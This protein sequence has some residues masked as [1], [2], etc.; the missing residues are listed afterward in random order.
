[1]VAIP[2]SL[3]IAIGWIDL[4]GFGL[5]QMGNTTEA[6]IHYQKGLVIGEALV[7]ADPYNAKARTDLATAH[8][9]VGE[10]RLALGEPGAAL[11]NFQKFH[12]ITKDIAAANPDKGSAQRELGVSLFKM[13]EFHMSL[14]QD[15]SR[16]RTERIGHWRNAHSWLQRALDVF[17]T[18]R[19]QNVLSSADA[20]VPDEMAAEIAKCVAAIEL[21]DATQ[22]TQD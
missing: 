14:G 22:P 11:V 15:D 21:L 1:M 19:D 16:D 7:R 6:L 20:N 9:R 4:S 17:A 3:L 10:I 5:Q 2:T 12:E 13:A 8:C 18:M